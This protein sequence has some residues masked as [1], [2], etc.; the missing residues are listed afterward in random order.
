MRMLR[1]QLRAVGG[2]ALSVRA[3]EGTPTAT[4]DKIAFSPWSTPL[5][6][7]PAEG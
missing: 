4:S 6:L 3:V 5:M 7:R 1:D 2:M